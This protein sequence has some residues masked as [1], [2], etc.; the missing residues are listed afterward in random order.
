[1]ADTAT[2][3]PVQAKIDELVSERNQILKEQEVLH[4]KYEQMNTR[5]CEINGSIQ[6]LVELFGKKKEENIGDT[7]NKADSASSTDE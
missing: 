6:V 4:D 1:M 2:K 7:E 5:L 3:N